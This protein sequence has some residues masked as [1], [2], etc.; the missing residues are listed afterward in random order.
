MW[1]EITVLVAEIRRIIKLAYCIK[2]I[3]D[4]FIQYVF[5][6]LFLCFM[7]TASQR[8]LVFGGVCKSLDFDPYESNRL[9]LHYML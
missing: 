4:S 9:N 6:F 5:L 7:Q 8:Y 2:W 3:Q 1:D